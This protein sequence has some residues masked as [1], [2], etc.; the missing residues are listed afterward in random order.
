MFPRDELHVFRLCC[1]FLSQ[2][3]TSPI[4]IRSLESRLTNTGRA[5]GRGGLRPEV[6]TRPGCQ[7]LPECENG[8]GEEFTVS[9][10]RGKSQSHNTG[11]KPRSR[12][13]AL[14]LCAP[15]ILVRKKL[16]TIGGRRYGS[17]TYRFRSTCS[18]CSCWWPQATHR[19]TTR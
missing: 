3:H 4:D 6:A 9:R 11:Q 15:V 10:Q 8:C 5:W 2:L 16:R 14:S 17:V 1:Q 13:G 19:Y 12:M 7:S 18:S